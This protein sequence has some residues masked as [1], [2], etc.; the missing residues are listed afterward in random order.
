MIVVVKVAEPC[1][2]IITVT[3]LYAKG[4]E[5]MYKVLLWDI[6]GTVLDFLAAEKAAIRA[7]FT[8]FG[9]G[10]CTDEM[11]ARY[12]NINKK[13]W[14]MLE[15]GQMTKPEI[16]VGRFNE[17]FATEGIVTNCAA[18]FNEEYQLRLGDTIVFF[19]D[20]YNLIKELRHHVKQYAVTNGTF[21]AQ[22]KKLNKSGLI[23]LFDGVFIS[24][25]IGFE[26]PDMRFF[27][28]VFATI[29]AYD[30]SEIL[31]IGDSLS[32]DMQGGNNAGIACCLYAPN[33]TPDTAG[34]R[35]DHHITNLH[36]IKDILDL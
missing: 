27:E 5:Q 24:E 35:I 29:P 4:Y 16:L 31:I 23:D 36:Q 8:H 22:E 3:I 25:K 26:K 9:L 1:G 6:D 17:F 13:Y 21:K 11:L 19:D 14:K 33:G 34:L 30:K 15:L 10:E 7:C 28:A 20:A 12:S 18:A 2:Q 32:S